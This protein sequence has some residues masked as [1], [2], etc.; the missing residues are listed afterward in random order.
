MASKVGMAT[1]A[2]I[3]RCQFSRPS[4]SHVAKRN[5]QSSAE[6]TI[7]VQSLSA[8]NANA[9]TCM[10]FILG[11]DVQT[12]YLPE[13]FTPTACEQTGHRAPSFARAIRFGHMI[14]FGCLSHSRGFSRIKWKKNAIVWGFVRYDTTT[15]Q[16]FIIRTC[17]AVSLSEE[18]VSFHST[19]PDA[20]WGFDGNGRIWI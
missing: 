18:I 7:N 15:F 19:N 8:Q 20:I 2:F 11:E 1:I 16:Y 14:H 10:T 3:S 13:H 12:I 4:E 9:N 17:L 6:R 5:A